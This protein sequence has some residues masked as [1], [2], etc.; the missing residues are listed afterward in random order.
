M[1]NAEGDTSSKNLVLWSVTRRKWDKLKD[2][3]EQW[4][5]WKWAR[6]GVTWNGPVLYRRI[7]EMEGIFWK[8]VPEV[9][10]VY[11]CHHL[12]RK[13]RQKINLQLFEDKFQMDKLWKG[14]KVN[15]WLIAISPLQ[16]VYCI[17]NLSL[18]AYM[19]D[20]SAN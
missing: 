16:I 10:Q 2:H 13:K 8:P 3:N 19:H 15:V 5:N 9:N 11:N 12:Q 4:I 20:G 14:Y 7:K 1:I 6:M 17:C 18:S